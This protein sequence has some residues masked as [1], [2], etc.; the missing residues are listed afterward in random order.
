VPSAKK[1]A[2][3]A[4]FVR[5]TNAQFEPD[6]TP[7]P[8][9]F[10]NPEYVRVV[11]RDLRSGTIIQMEGQRILVQEDADQVIKALADA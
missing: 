7:N 8:D 1:E 3:V 10:I 11:H 2:D 4:N 5:F 6:G 9:V